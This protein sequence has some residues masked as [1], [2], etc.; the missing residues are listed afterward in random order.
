MDPRYKEDSE[1]YGIK[2]QYRPIYIGKGNGKRLYD[3]LKYASKNGR[4]SFIV[5]KIKSLISQGLSPIIEKIYETTDEVIAYKMEADLIKIIGRI[6]IETGPL[7]NLTDGGIG[8]TSVKRKPWS[9]EHREKMIRLRRLSPPRKGKTNSIEMRRKQ[10]ESHKDKKFTDDHKEALSKKKSR[11]VI[12][13]EDNKEIE[14]KN[15]IE[16]SKYLKVSQSTVYVALKKNKMVN[17]KI[18]QLKKS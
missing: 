3:H 6:D 8:G 17:N 10:S 4:I 9:D 5:S 1:Y 2:F 12:L 15:A 18:I 14:F 7:T 13:Y 16:L 11:T